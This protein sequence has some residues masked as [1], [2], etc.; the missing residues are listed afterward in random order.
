MCQGAALCT[1]PSLLLWK[2]LCAS[3]PVSTETAWDLTSANAT[4]VSPARPA[5]KVS[6]NPEL[7]DTINTRL[8]SP[9]AVPK[10]QNISWWWEEKTKESGWW[11][12]LEL[13]TLICTYYHG[14]LFFWD[15]NKEK[16]PLWAVE[17]LPLLTVVRQ[18]LNPQHTWYLSITKNP[19]LPPTASREVFN[20]QGRHWGVGGRGLLWCE[21][22]LIQPSVERS[23]GAALSDFRSASAP[24]EITS[25]SL[26][27]DQ[28][29]LWCSIAWVCA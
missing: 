14:F 25:Q 12:C 7:G 6:L 20:H 10:H 22:L 3:P 26:T 19:A 24:E 4:L 29:T 23:G 5:I 1:D 15:L 17:G 2:Q 18:I 21:K 16:S 8:M 11:I 27:W 9:S 13:L 28:W